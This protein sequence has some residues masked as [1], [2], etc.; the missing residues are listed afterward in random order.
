MTAPT[1]T[2]A[3]YQRAI[4]EI[5]AGTVA[6]LLAIF[7]RDEIKKAVADL[8]ALLDTSDPAAAHRSPSADAN[9]LVYN[10]LLPLRNVPQ[11]AAALA[12]R[13]A[14]QLD[15]TAPSDPVADP[16]ALPVA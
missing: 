3:E 7:E 11:I 9:A 15:P 2:R 12:A 10:A 13:L 5:D 4:T 6:A 1:L 14:A 16:T 8:E